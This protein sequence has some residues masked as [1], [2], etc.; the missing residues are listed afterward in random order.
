MYIEWNPGNLNLDNL[1]SPCFYL[2]LSPTLFFV[3]LQSSSYRCSTVFN[4]KESI[5]VTLLFSERVFECTV[6]LV[7][8]RKLNITK[9]HWQYFKCNMLQG[10][11]LLHDLLFGC[12]FSLFVKVQSLRVLSSIFI[13]WLT[14]LITPSDGK[15]KLK[16]GEQEKKLCSIGN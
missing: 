15:K 1:N 16:R 13:R 14:S 9:G 6:W 7:I 4:L 5:S 10:A 8:L 11:V 3:S 2:E 12:N